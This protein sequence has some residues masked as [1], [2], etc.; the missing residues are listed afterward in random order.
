M[1][2]PFS[3][4]DEVAEIRAMRQT[5]GRLASMKAASLAFNVLREI[6]RGSLDPRSLAMAA[7][8]A[9]ED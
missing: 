5:N 1:M 7:V 3:I 9:D 6:A 8:K 4:A 2:T